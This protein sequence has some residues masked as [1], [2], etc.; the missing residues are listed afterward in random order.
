MDIY[1][2]SGI[3]QILSKHNYFLSSTKGQNYLIDKNTSQKIV[4][5]I[6]SLTQN[7]TY[8]L[9][10]GSGLGAITLPLAQTFEYVVTVEI[11]RGIAKCLEEVLEYYGVREKV[12]VIT[13]DFLKLHPSDIPLIDPQNTIFV[14][15]LPYNVAGEILKKIIYEYQIEDLFV[16]VQKEFFERIT[17]KQGNRNYSFVSVVTQLSVDKITKLLDVGKNSFFPIPSVDSV[18]INLKRSP[19]PIS[20]EEVKVIQK[21]FTTR[22]KTILNSIHT[23]FN[24][25][26]DIIRNLLLDL[27]IDEKTRIE[28]LPPI[29]IKDLVKNLLKLSSQK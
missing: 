18:F 9:E 2:P 8:V 6:K 20:E 17:A 12:K 3:R 21:L 24:H 4:K 14:S 22:R 16:M 27:N 28:N 26:K 5:L 23:L 10:V 29:T 19:L 1:S 11:D 15:N 7:K 25:S 13:K